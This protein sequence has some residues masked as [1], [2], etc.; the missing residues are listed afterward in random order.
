MEGIAKIDF[1]WKAFFLTSLGIVFYLFFY[2][3]V[4][5]FSD[6]VGLENKLENEAFF[7]K[8]RISRPGSGEAYPGVFGPSKDIK[9]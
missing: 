8:S 7:V 9:A 5:R 2:C 3:L 1:S 4:N 6:S